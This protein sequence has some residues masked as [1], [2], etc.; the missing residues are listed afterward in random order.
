M[1]E[2]TVTQDDDVIVIADAD[3]SS[4]VVTFDDETE[5]IQTFEQGPPGIQ[6]K[7]GPPGPPGG[8]GEDGNTIVYGPTNPSGADGVDGDFYINTATHFL[9]G[10]KA[11]GAWP[12]GTSLIGPQ[13]LPGNQGEPGADGNTVLYGAADPVAGTGV[14]GNFY[15][16]T[17]THFM[18]GPK[19]GGAWPAGTSLVGPQGLPG[20]QG[21]PGPGIADAPNDGVT[22]GRKSAAWASLDAAM[23]RYDAAQSLT[24]AQQMQARKN[25]AAAPLDALAYNGMQVN[26]AF[27]VNQSTADAAGFICDVWLLA[28]SSGAIIA[29]AQSFAPGNVPGCSNWLQI[30]VTTAQPSLGVGAYVFVQQKIEGYRCA[31]LDW[32]YS[33]ARPITIGFWCLHHRTGTYSGAVRDDV[34]SRSYA[35]TYTQN[36]ADTPEYKT[37]TIPGDTAG[38]AS[39]WL[40]DNR[41]GMVID[42]ALA[43]GTQFTAP[44]ANIWS[45]GNYIAAPGQVNAVASTADIFRISGIT[46]LPGNDAPSAERAPY[47]QRPFDQELALCQRYFQSSWDHGVAP[48]TAWSV[49]SDHMLFTHPSG[50]FSSTIPI[51]RM[52]ASPTLSLFASNGAP[53]ALSYYNGAGWFDNGA[54]SASISKQGLIFLQHQIANSTYTNFGFKLDARL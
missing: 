37:V 28:N 39:V 26:G 22:Y 40:R 21:P 2:V 3:A 4:I 30:A 35:F 14:N 11:A 13:G 9:Y 44:A 5:V 29:P 18:F 38:T 47:L 10:P 53:N 45:A 27:E 25:I 34:G 48:G 8:P 43:C 20:N 17:T 50:I 46:V 31:R 33:I 23:V 54:A 32:G 49:G 42:F 12:A 6:G 1:T 15:I 52:R 19:A 16:N 41:A 7:P 51:S 24:A 36:V